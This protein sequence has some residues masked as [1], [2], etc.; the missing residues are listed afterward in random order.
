MSG[1]WSRA[2]VSRRVDGLIMM[3][4]GRDQSYLL[5]E[6]RAG[7]A[8]VFIDRPPSFLDADAVRHRQPRRRGAT[9]YAT[10]S[11]RATGASASWAT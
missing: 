10:S 5:N 8:I 3:P 4:A 2:F 6:R 7:L 9:G 1:S 11:R